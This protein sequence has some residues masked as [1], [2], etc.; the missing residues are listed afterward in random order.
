MHKVLPLVL[1]LSLAAP[2]LAQEPGRRSVS[3]FHFY[4]EVIERAPLTPGEAYAV[5][6]SP[7]A[8]ALLRER[9]EVRVFDAFQ[10][11]VPSVLVSEPE[12]MEVEKRAVRVINEAWEAGLIQ[13]FTVELTDRTPEP[14]TTFVLDIADES[15]NARAVIEGS[16]DGNEWMTV[17]DNLHLIRHTLPGE[18]V[19]FVHNRLRIPASR[20]KYFRFT[21]AESGRRRPLDIED[22]AVLQEIRRGRS[23]AL[24]VHP[25]PWNNPED[26]DARHVWYKLQL[27]ETHL[28]VD[29]LRLTIDAREYERRGVLYEW[30]VELERPR[31]RPIASGI[32]FHYG[33]DRETEL[34]GFTTD[35]GILVLMIDQGDDEPVAVTAVTAYRPRQEVRFIMEDAFAGPLRL[36]FK[37]ERA[38][39]PQ[40][41]LPRRLEEQKIHDFVELEH[42][43]L[44]DNPAFE[45]PPPP[46]SERIPYLMYALILLVAV[47]LAVYIART[48]RMSMPPE[49]MG[50]DD[51]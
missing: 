28:G 36:Y 49:D 46:V 35:A 38:H 26:A 15:Y 20:Y 1:A 2:A 39:A 12:H 31:R 23:L 16:D 29:R 8:S 3:D 4:A 27:P 25:A 32:L 24:P 10:H 41:D 13:R 21:I 11:E 9:P 48:V 18:D 22:V 5:G 50:G 30:N 42:G 34:H 44:R 33:D 7:K 19:K 6:L 37:P 14:V 43:P 51:A 17:R 47:V 45:P 40:Y